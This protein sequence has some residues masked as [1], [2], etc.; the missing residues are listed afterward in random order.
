MFQSTCKLF[1]CSFDKVVKIKPT[2]HWECGKNQ[3]CTK[4][5]KTKL[6]KKQQ[7]TSDVTKGFARM[8]YSSR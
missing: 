7:I 8:R 6:R 5:R 4:T 3:N 2:V 1:P